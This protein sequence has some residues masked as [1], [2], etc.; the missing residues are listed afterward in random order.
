MEWSNVDIGSVGTAIAAFVS[1]ASLAYGI[2]RNARKDRVEKIDSDLGVLRTII[3]TLQAE[4][5][6]MREENKSI[7]AE[8]QAIRQEN[9]AIRNRENECRTELAD[10]RREFE[11][12]RDKQALV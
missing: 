12:Y 9:K 8:N 3:T 10:L 5:T 6:S 11:D 4:N 1:I 2:V 7:R